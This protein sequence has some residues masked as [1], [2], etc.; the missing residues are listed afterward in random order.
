ME[1]IFYYTPVFRLPEI[2]QGGKISASKDWVRLDWD[3]MFPVGNDC[4]ELRKRP[5]VWLTLHN[6]PLPPDEIKGFVNPDGVEMSVEGFLKSS[7]GIARLV[8]P[9]QKDKF[10]S[11]AKYRHLSK[12]HPLILNYL[13]TATA[14]QRRSMSDYWGSLD[15]IPV[16]KSTRIEFLDE[17][18][19]WESLQKWVVK[20]G[21]LN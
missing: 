10:I 2:I 13:E 4:P 19:S 15:A 6:R 3:T 16:S 20:N 5:A 11:W 9:F 1:S 12:G 8:F 7:G 14:K 21:N 18:G 17:D